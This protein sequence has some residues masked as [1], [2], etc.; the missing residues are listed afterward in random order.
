VRNDTIS[1]LEVAA[2]V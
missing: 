2:S 1:L